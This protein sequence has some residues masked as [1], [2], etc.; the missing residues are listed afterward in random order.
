MSDKKPRKRK[1]LATHYSYL[2]G[3]G[4]DGDVMRKVMKLFNLT[5]VTPH[6]RRILIDNLIQ[7]DGEVLAMLPENFTVDCDLDVLEQYLKAGLK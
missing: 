1:G 2:G 6:R 7:R 5:Q 3:G 4:G